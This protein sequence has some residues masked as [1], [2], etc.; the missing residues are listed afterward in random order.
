M[1]TG[2]KCQFV[3]IDICVWPCMNGSCGREVG[4]RIIHRCELYTGVDYTLGKTVSPTIF[5]L[6]IYFYFYYFYIMIND[7]M[8]IRSYS[9]IR[10][11]S[12]VFTLKN[13]FQSSQLSASYR[14]FAK[15]GLLGASYTR[16]YTVIIVRIALN[17]YTWASVNVTYF[18]ELTFPP[19]CTVHLLP[20][21]LI[22]IH[23]SKYI[24]SQ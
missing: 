24:R 7:M 3:W 9:V 6:I 2:F 16:V 20:Y 12:L 14:A 8:H 5:F 4:V 19:M 18:S 15:V 22:N 21:N 13:Y 10:W 11:F 17:T 1:V 23:N